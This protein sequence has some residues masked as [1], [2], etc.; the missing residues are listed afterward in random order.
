MITDIFFGSGENS[1]QIHLD[2]LLCSGQEETLL[3]CSHDPVGVN[4]CDHAEDVGVI[5]QRSEGK[6]YW[7]SAHFSVGVL[8]SH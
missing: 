1:Q 7:S 3:E 2:E 8:L 4:D 6:I 5:C